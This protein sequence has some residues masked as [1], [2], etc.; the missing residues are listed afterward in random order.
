L[1]LLL[2]GNQHG[3]MTCLASCLNSIRHLL[4]LF[5]T[6]LLLLF[7]LLVIIIFFIIPLLHS[8][9]VLLLCRMQLCLHISLL[10]L[11]HVIPLRPFLHGALHRH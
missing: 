7:P 9:L 3:G 2:S 1:L 5:L 6:F 4:L 11:L 10:P 8:L